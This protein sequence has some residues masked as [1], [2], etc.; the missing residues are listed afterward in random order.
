MTDLWEQFQGRRQPTTTVQLP[1]DP[2]SFAEAEDA[3]E[4]ATRALQ[5]AQLRGA[6][7]EDLAQL[8]SALEAAEGELA[9]QASIVFTVKPVT[10]VDWDDLVAAHP[11]TDDQ[12]K[13]GWGWNTPNFR[14]A[15]LSIALDPTLSEHQ[16]HAI[17]ESGQ[18]GRGELDA[19]FAAVVQLSSRAPHIT[20]GKG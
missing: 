9:G 16:W 15:L 3:V 6:P 12:R 2:V 19:L 4:R 14:A 20:V 13:Q 7:D 1:V 18:I 5:D 17:A 8:R 11:P 10:A